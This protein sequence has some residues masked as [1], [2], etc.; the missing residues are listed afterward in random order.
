MRYQC[1]EIAGFPSAD[2]PLEGVIVYNDDNNLYA[3][4]SN[5][6]TGD[7]YFFPREEGDDLLDFEVS[8]DGRYVTYDHYSARTGEDRSVIATAKGQLIW[9][10]TISGYAW[11]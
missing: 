8:P 7:F 6:E 11:Q 1:L 9:S 10:K 2:H 4:L 5:E 3:Y